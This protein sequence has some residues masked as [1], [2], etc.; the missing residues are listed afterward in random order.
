MI[1]NISNQKYSMK[2][3]NTLAFAMGLIFATGCTKSP[4]PCFTADNGNNTKTNE[5]VQFD[6][7]CSQNSISFFWEFG[8]GTSASGAPV[9]HKYENPGT[10]IVKLTASN[11]KKSTSTSQNIGITP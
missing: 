6:P 3:F 4:V 1:V 10:Y 7:S 9:K 5:E 8:D 2:I 11:K